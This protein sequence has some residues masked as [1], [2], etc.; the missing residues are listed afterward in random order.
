M[1]LQSIVNILYLLDS[2]CSCYKNQC[3]DKI[4]QSGL[5]HLFCAFVENAILFSLIDQDGR[6]THNSSRKKGRVLRLQDGNRKVLKPMSAR[7]FGKF[8]ISSIEPNCGLLSCIGALHF[9]L[10]LAC[11]RAILTLEFLVFNYVF[12]FWLIVS[13]VWCT[14]CVCL[15]VLFGLVFGFSVCCFDLEVFI[16][17]GFS[18]HFWGFLLCIVSLLCRSFLPL[19]VVFC[20]WNLVLYLHWL[21]IV[22]LFSFV[23][24]L[25]RLCVR[26]CFH[27]LL[28]ARFR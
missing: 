24:C 4:G 3:P 10:V 5:C 23:F 13:C 25:R 6:R 15:G 14:W 8:Y 20:L 26:A 2:E 7:K 16:A 1:S 18:T 9:G 27:V 19:F 17:L 21:L 12:S 28:F 22:I 11:E